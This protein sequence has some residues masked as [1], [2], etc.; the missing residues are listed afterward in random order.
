MIKV[1]RETE[2][3]RVVDCGVICATEEVC[4]NGKVVKL[5]ELGKQSCF[6]CVQKLG[7][8]AVTQA[9]TKSVWIGNRPI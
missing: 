8:E 5:L 2:E 6:M 1:L 9:S 3:V 4:L 7:R